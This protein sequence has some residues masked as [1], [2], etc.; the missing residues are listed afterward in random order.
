MKKA[1]TKLT[2]PQASVVILIEHGW[3]LGTGDGRAWLQKALCHGGPSHDVNWHTFHALLARGI[4]VR[5]RRHAGDDYWL[6]RYRLAHP[7]GRLI[8]ERAS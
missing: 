8:K 6:T 2:A 3:Q 5:A 4:I 7:H 1:F